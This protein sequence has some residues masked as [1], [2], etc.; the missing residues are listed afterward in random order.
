MLKDKLWVMVIESKKAD[1]SIEKGL[2]QILAY[3]LGSAVE[4][5]PKFGTIATG[6]EFIF[7]KLVKKIDLVTLYQRGF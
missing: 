3:M 1:Y 4:N 6:S 7:V 5:K 2:A